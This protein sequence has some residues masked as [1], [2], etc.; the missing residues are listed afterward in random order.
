MTKK[1]TFTKAQLNKI[2]APEKEQNHLTPSAEDRYKPFPLTDL[3]QAYW[4]GRSNELQGGTGMQMYLEFR[5]R[6]FDRNRFTKALNLLVHRHDMLRCVIHG[7]GQQR[8]LENAPAME[9][10]YENLTGFNPE[11]QKKRLEVIALEMQETVADLEKW[12]QSQFRFSATSGPND[13][14]LHFKW[15]MWCFDGRSFQIIFED[16]ATLYRDPETALPDLNLRFRDYVLALEKFEQSETYKNDLAYW[17][18]KLTTLP[19]PPALPR[20]PAKKKSAVT[21]SKGF[22]TFTQTLNPQRTKAIQR[23]CS[24]HGLSLT[25]FMG[26]VYSEVIGLWSGMKHFTLNFPRFNRNLDWHSDVSDIVGEFASFTLL[27]VNLD[28][29]ETFLERAKNLQQRM[30]TDL[31]HGSVSGLRLL[32]EL[33]REKGALE[34]QAMPVVFTAMPDRRTTGKA[35]EQAI[36]SF[37]EVLSTKGETPQVQLDCQYFLLNDGLKINWDTQADAYPEGLTQDMFEEY[38]RLLELFADSEDIWHAKHPASAPQAHLNRRDD[39]NNIP[40]ELPDTTVFE[41]F[42]NKATEHPD[43]IAVVS[44]NEQIS[45]SALLNHARTI[46]SRILKTMEKGETHAD[47]GPTPAVG[48]LLKRGWKQVAAV[49]GIQ[50]AGFA[51]LPLDT[52][53][54]TARLQRILSAGRPHLVI[55]EDNFM[56]TGSNSATPFFHIDELLV[57][58]TNLPLPRGA[59]KDDPAYMIFTSGSTGTPKG[60]T[61]G[62]KALLNLVL[63][64]NNRFNIDESDNI[65]AVT[66]LHHDLSVFDIFGAAASGATLVCMDQD[67]ALDPGHWADLMQKGKITFWNSVPMLM[68]HLLNQCS[69]ETL[70]DLRLVILGGDWLD[71]GLP[72]RLTAMAPNAQLISIGGPTETTVWNIMNEAS[73]KPDGWDSIPYGK[74]I[75]NSSYYIL[76][77]EHQDAPDW[78]SGEMYCGGVPLCMCSNTDPELD[79]QNFIKHPRTEERIYRTGDM[80]RYRPEGLIEIL[81]RKDFQLN[82]NGYR[83]DPAEVEKELNLHPCVQ[84]AVVSAVGERGSEILGAF[85]VPGEQRLDARELRTWLFSR[86]P[87]QMQPKAI[88]VLDEFPLTANGKLDRK[89]LQSTPLDKAVQIQEEQRA[90]TNAMEMFLKELWEE[91]LELEINGAMSNFFELGGN[92]LK[93]MQVLARI[94]EKLFIRHPLASFFSAPTIAELADALLEQL[95]QAGQQKTAAGGQ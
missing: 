90:P 73:K 20:P 84:R 81:G 64:T 77:T 28:S 92:S 14:H 65:L 41:L 72:E 71:P 3:Q 82:I 16:L 18:D 56:E 69:G 52:G 63:Y 67:K 86:L 10:K 79:A 74:P 12:P 30:W 39:Q 8:V 6:D 53:S 13:G 35:L 46:G 4:I 60:V 44:G 29:G 58:D 48:V 2:L 80:G 7:D 17:Q 26:A 87:L 38:M 15:D 45:F 25:S 22:V 27:E 59:R 85:I 91:V 51:Y 42:T 19:P 24:Y 89:A 54:P 32:R 5:C 68:E 40:L 37:G 88:F 83:L 34:I 55:T 31:E 95:A 76:T 1:F 36:D 75:D 61:V 78:V 94:E 11:E 93:A 21:G 50:A 62:Q 49:L 33:T 70:P 57:P 43:K 9:V 23:I 66:A 47:P